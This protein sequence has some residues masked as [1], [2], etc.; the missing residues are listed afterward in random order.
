VLI[1]GQSV[2]FIA[3]SRNIIIGKH[4]NKTI[5]EDAKNVTKYNIL[6]CI[7]LPCCFF[8]QFF[9]LPLSAHNLK[10]KIKRS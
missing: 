5:R 7:Y 1:L 6:L 9:C 10:L 4:T 2:G 8:F 3:Y